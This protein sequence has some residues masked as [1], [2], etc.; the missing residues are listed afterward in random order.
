MCENGGQRA[1][2]RVVER[3]PEE[4]VVERQAVLDADA[5]EV[6]E[7]LTEESLLRDWLA[8]EAEI[9]PVEGGE[10]AF[11]FGDGERCGTVV[12]ADPE[13]R[14]AFTWE[15]PGEGQ[16]LVELTLEPVTG[17]T[18]LVVVERARPGPVALAG[19]GWE[20]RLKGLELVLGRG[21]VLA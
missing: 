11:R 20:A 12:E 2:E 6:W 18:R 17:G 14:L 19:A 21:L 5:A 1:E 13:R 10:V 15:R 4:R 16:S 9:D 7:A 8:D 3:E